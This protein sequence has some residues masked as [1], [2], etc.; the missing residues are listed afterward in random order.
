MNNMATEKIEELILTEEQDKEFT[1]GK[2]TPEEK[3]SD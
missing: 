2:G 1:N 3:E